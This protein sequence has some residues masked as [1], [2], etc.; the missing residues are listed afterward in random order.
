MHQTEKEF[1]ADP[2]LPFLI[3]FSPVSPAPPHDSTD[4]RIPPQQHRLFELEFVNFSGALLSPVTYEMK[5]EI[6]YIS[7]FEGMEKFFRIPDHNLN[8]TSSEAEEA[9]TVYIRK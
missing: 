6:D 5:I 8:E 1:T 2:P 7:T 3:R 4:Q 9:E